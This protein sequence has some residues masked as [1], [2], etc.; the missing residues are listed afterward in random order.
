[1][2]AVLTQKSGGIQGFASNAVYLKELP[3]E[4]ERSYVA[5]QYKFLCPQIW[6]CDYWIIDI[7]LNS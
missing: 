5:H 2:K 3:D 1:M 4:R 7:S 6:A